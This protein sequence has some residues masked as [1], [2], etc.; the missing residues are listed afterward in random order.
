MR[1]TVNIS[2]PPPMKEW[3]EAQVA[4]GGYGTVSEYVRHLV[5]AEQQ[6]QLRQQV[7]DQLH[8]GLDSGDATPMTADDWKH[9]R[10][11]GRKRLA[12]AKRRPS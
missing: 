6:R 2:L 9:I 4:V 3:I 12:A 10:Q 7:D 8:A 11:E 5:R 1:A